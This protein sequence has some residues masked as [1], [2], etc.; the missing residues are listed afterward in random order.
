MPESPSPAGPESGPG[1]D[2]PADDTGDPADGD[3]DEAAGPRAEEE[4]DPVQSAA[5]LG[6]SASTRRR[7]RR[8]GQESLGGTWFEDAARFAGPASFG[9]GHAI[10]GNVS[11]AGRDINYI[12]GDVAARRPGTDA[13]PIALALL[14]RVR[15]THVQGGSYARAEQALRATQ[16]VILRGASGSGKRTSALRLLTE[17]T[18]EDVHEIGVSTA[19]GPPSDAELREGAGYLAE[20]DA[21]TVFAYHRTAAWA[22][23]L[24]ELNAYL[25]VTV[26]AGAAVGA[27]VAEHFLIDH[28]P[29]G[30]PAIV[31]SHLHADQVHGAKAEL[32]LDNSGVLPCATSPDAATALAAHLL[33]TVRDTLPEA[34]LAP[35]VR[36]LRGKEAR[37]MLGTERLAARRDRVDLLCR[38]AAMISIAVFAGLSYADAMAA[39]ETLAA[40]FIAIEFPRLSGAGR[41]LFVR[42]RDLLEAEPG[43]SIE[44]S[45]LPTRWGPV[46]VRCIRF[47]DPQLHGVMLEE[48]WERYDGVRSPLLGWLG[49]LALHAQDEAVAIRAAQVVGRFAIRDFGHVCHGL[50]A[51][52]AN[53]VNERHRET[54]ATALEAAATGRQTHV[55]ELLKEWCDSGSQHRQRTAILALGTTIGEGDHDGTLDRLRELALRGS[56]GPGRSV[57]EAV[58]RSLID[59]M[60]GPHQEA[61]VRA[62]RRWAEEKN[63]ARLSSL[64]R[65]CVPPLAHVTD[66]RER[67]SFLAALSAVPTLR[68]EATSL[69][70]AAL[71]DS[72]TKQET[73]LALERLTV[74][75]ASEPQHIQALG[76][77]LYGLRLALG[78]EGGQLIFYLHLWA[79]RHDELTAL[80]DDAD[81]CAPA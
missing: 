8:A 20:G 39:A 64:A 40:A 59:L 74:A 57:A 38:R 72:G 65:R 10:G 13:G 1:P 62:L 47:R 22:A 27:D 55:W 21:G 12:F 58:R 60:S 31:R 78:A 52:W 63:N 44:E 36:A 50:I 3:G 73:W 81:A 15:A 35:F 26:P 37:R 76:E 49:D 28:I 18:G 29:P 46:P 24:S 45:V 14:A 34:S 79:R 17:L 6:A 54:A 2:A 16:I 66:D 56:G 68:T 48:I 9:S 4:D 69:F 61:V 70:A 77:L 7:L 53:S 43:I 32:F 5:E 23:R 67:P 19:L 30:G 51:G 71:T 80:I 11:K 42:W 75:A 41:E 33:A 25:I